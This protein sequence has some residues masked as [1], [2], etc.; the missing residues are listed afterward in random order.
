MSPCIVIYVYTV[1]GQ[2]I[3]G[4][5]NDSKRVMCLMSEIFHIFMNDIMSSHMYI[6]K[7]LC[8]QNPI[9]FLLK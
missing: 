5:F 1:Q 4:R 9:L 7:Y 6:D 8:S 2:F 3:L